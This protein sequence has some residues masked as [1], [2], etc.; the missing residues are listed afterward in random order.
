MDDEAAP[1]TDILE[2]L[3]ETLLQL[4]L[5]TGFD[6]DRPQLAAGQLKHEIDLRSAGGAIEARLGPRRRDAEQVFDDESLPAGPKDRMSSELIKVGESKQAMSNA[7]IAYVQPRRFDQTFLG[8]VVKRRQTPH[9]QKIGQKIDIA[10][11]SGRRNRQAACERCG[12]EKLTL[13]V[14]Q[15]GPQALQGLGR[16]ARPELRH[17]PFQVSA[18]EIASKHIAIVITARQIATGETSPYPKGSLLMQILSPGLENVERLHI[19]VFDP[20]GKALAGLTKQVDR[21]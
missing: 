1:R 4:R 14:R 10:A 5:Q 15:H 20:S 16:H 17:I 18:D 21:R 11:H 9:Q 13:V 12:V 8:V 6:L 3:A 19:D 7:A 2:R